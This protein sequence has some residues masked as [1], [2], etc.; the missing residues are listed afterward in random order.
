MKLKTCLIITF[1]TI[2]LMMN[3]NNDYDIYIYVCTNCIN[4]IH[5]IFC[6]IFY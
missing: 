1:V 2:E 3:N 5:I 4:Y 6:F